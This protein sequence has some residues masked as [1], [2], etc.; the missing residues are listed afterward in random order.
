MRHALLLAIAQYRE[1]VDL[2]DGNTWDLIQQIDMAK[3]CLLQYDEAIAQAEQAL[4][5]Q[6]AASAD[7]DV[8][9]LGQVGISHDYAQLAI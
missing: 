1:E 6:W 4:F 2:S 7:A 9:R 3:R 5:Q 8:K